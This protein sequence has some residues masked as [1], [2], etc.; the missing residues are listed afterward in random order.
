MTL[1]DIQK[2]ILANKKR[3]G[4]NTTNIEQ[5]FCY[6]YLEI[7]E[8]YEAYYN[9]PDTFAEELADVAIFL[10]GIAEINGIDLE[11]E[12]IEAE[13]P[14]KSVKISINIANI[15]KEICYLYG[16]V[17]NAYEAYIKRPDTFPTKLAD[18]AIYLFKFAEINNIDIKAEIYKKVEINKH[19]IYKRN[20]AGNWVKA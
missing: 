11:K 15:E 12:I 4:F 8:V 9:A 14:A 1:K 18:I 5:E 3:R 7:G 20:E 10:L 6:L 19:R 2:E 16:I 13:A 17:R